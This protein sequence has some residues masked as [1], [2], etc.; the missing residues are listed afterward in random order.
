MS[1]NK[2]NY[3]F[4]KFIADVMGKVD[5]R[6]QYE[7]SMLSMF[8]MMIGLL[9]SVIYGSIYTDFKLWFKITLWVNAFFGLLFMTSYLITTFQQYKSYMEFKA[10]QENIPA[11]KST[12]TTP[13]IN[14]QKEVLENEATK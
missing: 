2:S 13:I 4:P 6:V 1:K 5:Q 8:F 11:L 7:A 9:L 12:F 10:L 14:N 3:I